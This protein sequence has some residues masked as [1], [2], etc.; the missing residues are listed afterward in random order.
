MEILIE[1]LISSYYGSNYNF[2]DYFSPE[3][4]IMN[5]SWPKLFKI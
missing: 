4:E 1:Y 3:T 5:L 2:H